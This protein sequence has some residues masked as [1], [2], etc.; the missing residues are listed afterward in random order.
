MK[1]GWIKVMMSATNENDS[2]WD[3][4]YDNIGPFDGLFSQGV[5]T[6]DY[7]GNGRISYSFRDSE[8]AIMFSLRWL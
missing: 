3:W 4:C 5:W 6:T 1:E 7:E 2:I 8:A